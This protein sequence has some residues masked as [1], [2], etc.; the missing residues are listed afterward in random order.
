MSKIDNIN[1]FDKQFPGMIGDYYEP[2]QVC[3]LDGRVIKHPG[4]VDGGDS[5][6]RV[7]SY[8]VYQGVTRGS[9]G[10]EEAI[11][12]D[13]ECPGCKG[14]FR[15]H[16]DS[17][18]WYSD[19]DRMSRDQT[20][21]LLSAMA[22]H[23]PYYL[24]RHFKDHLSRCLLFTTNTRRNGATKANHGMVKG[25]HKTGDT[26]DY[27]WKMPDIT[28]MDVW[29]IY[30]R[31]FRSWV[32]WPLLVIFDLQLLANSILIKMNPDKV[33]IMQHT[34]QILLAKHSMPTPISFLAAE[35][36][37]IDDY[38]DRLNEYLGSRKE[39]PLFLVD[40]CIKALRARL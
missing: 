39:Q 38:K 1:N 11:F 25:G 2:G 37:N 21:P 5:A 16:P 17:D 9:T 34:C 10:N 18:Y 12:R 28:F 23:S 14:R 3:P 20:I 40:E 6:H 24:N 22:I 32:L 4:W 31:G 30:I 13:L 26:Y 36:I 8:L 15:R 7:G 29:A 33:D 19:C 27:S 35:F